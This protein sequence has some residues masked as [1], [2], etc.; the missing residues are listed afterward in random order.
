LAKIVLQEQIVISAEITSAQEYH[1]YTEQKM[2]IDIGSGGESK[3]DIARGN[4]C[5]DLVKK[6]KNKRSNK[7]T[8]SVNNF[9]TWILGE[10]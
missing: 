2:F 7:T 6:P 9:L 8:Y 3:L 5:T 10:V 1:S 4:V